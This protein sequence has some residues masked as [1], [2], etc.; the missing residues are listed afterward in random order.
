MLY[1]EEENEMFGW[2]GRIGLII[3]SNN[4]VMEYEFSR[5]VP[6]GFSVHTAR[7]GLVKDSTWETLIK[8]SDH[9]E[10]ATEELASCDVNIIVYGCTSGSFL[11]GPKFEEELTERIYKISNVTCFTTSKAVLE[12][13][14]SLGSKNVAIASPYSQMTNEAE[15][16]FL[17]EEGFKVFQMEGLGIIR[18]T[19]IGRLSPYQAY[20][21]AKRVNSEEVDTLFISCT[22]FR[23][24]EIIAPLE[25]DLK[26]RVITSNQASLWMA[27]RLLTLDTEDMEKKLGSLFSYE[28]KKT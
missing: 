23:T 17:E 13:L 20:A 3:P 11:K 12:A 25:K 16:K 19:D 14:R 8:M 15:K 10:R 22:D 4:T 1:D 9:V 2:R 18:P 27:I 7:L 28:I 6:E 5:A 21:M 26:K 24:F